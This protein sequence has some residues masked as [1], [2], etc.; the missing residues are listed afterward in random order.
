MAKK[1][2]LK[3]LLVLALALVAAFTGLSC[4]LVVLQVLRHA[5]LQAREENLTRHVYRLEPRR[6]DILD[7][8]G[9]LLATSIFVK[10]VCANPSLIGSNYLEVA[11]ALAPLLET[12]ET[13]L[14]KRLRP[15]M[16]TNLFHQTEPVQYVMLKQ[17]V[18]EEVW[19]N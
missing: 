8:K 1:L 5:E 12:N 18:P 13:E 16:S 10:T 14:A 6:G 9:H 19:E 17:K 2:Q 3:R 7:V 4:R 11:H 15:R